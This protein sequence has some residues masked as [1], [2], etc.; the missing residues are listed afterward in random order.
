MLVLSLSLKYIIPFAIP[1]PVFNQKT[2]LSQRAEQGLVQAFVP[3]PADEALQKGILH[4]LVWR[5]VMPAD[6][7]FLRP[8]ENR[9]TDQLGTVVRDD[10]HRLAK[11]RQ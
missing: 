9:M 6:P 10:Q 11:Q 1:P 8:P 7:G 3:Q 4:R 5:D 2:C